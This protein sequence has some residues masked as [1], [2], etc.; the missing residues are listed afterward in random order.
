[1]NCI[2]CST[3]LPLGSR[4][5]KRFCD[6]RCERKYKQSLRDPIACAACGFLFKPFKTTS[7][8]CSRTCQIRHAVLTPE[9]QAR[10]GKIGGK[11]NLGRGKQQWYVKVDGK[12][13]HRQIAEEALGRPLKSNEVVHHIDGNK[14]NNA[15][16]NLLI[17]TQA[18]H[19]ALHAKMRTHPGP[20]SAT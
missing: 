17:C 19:A 9:H 6:H 13:L 20:W 12:H 7:V 4:A 18:Y 14:R 16:S 5:S 8:Y 2:W 10:A 1:M 3:A 11:T 15:K